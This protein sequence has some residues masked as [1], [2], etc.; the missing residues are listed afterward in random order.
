MLPNMNSHR[1]P[2]TWF[3]SRH[4]GALE[5]A[6]RHGVHSDRQL[7]HLDLTLI[8]RNDI[9]IGTLP[10]PMAAAVAERG[11]RFLHLSLTLPAELRGKELDADALERCGARLEEFFIRRSPS[12]AGTGRYKH[13]ESA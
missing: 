12:A 8:Q 6:Q 7:A 13:K 10:I 4:P 5:W 9:V 11:A 2:L 1:P 3:I